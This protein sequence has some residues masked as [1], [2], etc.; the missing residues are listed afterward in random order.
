VLRRAPEECFNAAIDALPRLGA[1]PAQIHEAEA[2]AGRHVT[3]G[4]SPAAAL[5]GAPD[6][7]ARLTEGHL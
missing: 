2:I 3:P 4:R 1:P 7:P 5:L 6:V